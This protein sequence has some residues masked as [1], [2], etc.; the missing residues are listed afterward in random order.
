MHLASL[1]KPKHVVGTL[2]DHIEI[3]GLEAAGCRSDPV[4]R[5]ERD[6]G[7]VPLPSRVAIRSP[8]KRLQRV[9]AAV[10]E[11]EPVT[12]ADHEPAVAPRA[13]HVDHAAH[14]QVGRP[15][16]RFGGSR[17]ETSEEDDER[18]GSRQR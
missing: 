3:V 13:R 2:L 14:V 8:G 16:R 9:P 12:A 18:H 10:E 1:V 15:G 17:G 4:A 6:V 11:V 5:G 7:F